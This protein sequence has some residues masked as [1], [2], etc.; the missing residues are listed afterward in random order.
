VMVFSQSANAQFLKKLKKKVENSVEQTVTNKVANKAAR[1]TSKS[2]D[3]IL[4]KQIGKNNP[5]PMG[6]EK[7]DIS[8]VA[9]EYEFEWIY[10]LKME[11]DKSREDFQIEYYLKE[12]A[13]Y[14]GARMLNE[15][16]QQGLDLFM[17]Y[18]NERKLTVMFMTND[19]NRFASVS[20]IPEDMLEPD[21]YDVTND[22]TMT[23]IEGKQL[24]GYECEGFQFE[25][26]EYI[27]KTYVTFDTVISFSDVYGKSENM[28]KNFNPEWFNHEDNEGLV[29]ELGMID[30]RKEKNNMKMTCFRLEQKDY[31]IIKSNYQSF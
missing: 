17:L 31:S 11:M 19:G 18:D 10:G 25:N 29:M 30:K 20:Q 26:D 23:K 16:I 2:M 28:P 14:W 21:E 5:M 9:D 1:E 15:E 8:D 22:Y 3:K 13:P 4:N 27:I 6:G 24:L 7:G 12:D